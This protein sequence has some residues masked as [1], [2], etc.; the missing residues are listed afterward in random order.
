MLNK[1]FFEKN[2]F[3][4]SKEYRKKDYFELISKLT[5][6]HYKKCLLYKRILD[7][8]NQKFN[9]KKN[10]ENIPIIPSRIFKN[11]DLISVPKNKIVKILTS[12]GT[13]NS[14]VSKIF[15]DN[16]NASN[17]VKALKKLM[18]SIIGMKRL[19]M[20]IIDKDPRFEDRK[21]FSAKTAAILGFSYFGKN[22]FYLLDKYG[23]LISEGFASL[24]QILQ[25]KTK[26]SLRPII[27]HHQILMSKEK[28]IVIMIE[29]EIEEVI[30]KMREIPS[31]KRELFKLEEYPKL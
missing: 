27:C 29:K 9:F 1:N 26:M 11:Y 18:Q 23:N 10:L 17:Q 22:H 12:S 7:T 20:M 5:V 31:G 8:L 4:F 19:P 21:K 30:P 13:T 3:S 14:K 16:E 28:V 6:H 25:Q 24:R 15:L 2:P